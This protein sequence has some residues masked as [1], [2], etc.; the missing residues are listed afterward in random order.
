MR[1]VASLVA[2]WSAASAIEVNDATFGLV[3][4]PAPLPLKSNSLSLSLSP[5]LAFFLRGLCPLGL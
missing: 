5:P 2:M 4:P 3:L 1:P